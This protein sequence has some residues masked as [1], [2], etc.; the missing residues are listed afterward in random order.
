MVDYEKTNYRIVIFVCA[1][2]AIFFLIILFGTIITGGNDKEIVDTHSVDYIVNN[3]KCSYSS[4]LAAISYEDKI[5]FI[6]RDKNF[7]IDYTY[8]MPN[9]DNYCDDNFRLYNFYDNYA[10][11]Y[12]DGSYLV[13][14][15]DNVIVNTF[16]DVYV[17]FLELNDIKCVYVSYGEEVRLYCID[18]NK[19]IDVKLNNVSV[20]KGKIVYSTDDS[21]YIDGDFLF[22]TKDDKKYCYNLKT[23]TEFELNGYSIDIVRDEY[24]VAKSEETLFLKRDGNKLF[25]K[26]NN[27]KDLFNIELINN[28][29]EVRFI[30]ANV[31]AGKYFFM[32]IN[33]D[34]FG[35]IDS[36]GNEVIEVVKNLPHAGFAAV[37]IEN[38]LIQIYGDGTVLE[39]YD[40]NGKLIE[41]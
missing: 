2:C 30:P 6:D 37:R 40:F 15:K 19:I 41:E 36:K 35:V 25:V 24:S 4:N 13:I 34:K 8:D 16:D 22:Y 23:D 7:V 27:F 21:N 32:V 26:N 38:N 14:N 29:E 10:M 33:D 11:V 5:G 3:L 18:R 9:Y 17:P 31:D 28:Y 12:K 1:L 39:E 20:D